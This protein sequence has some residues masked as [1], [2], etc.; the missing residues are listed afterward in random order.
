MN[1]KLYVNGVWIP[2]KEGKTFPVY[3]P[4]TK[5]VIAHVA[6]AG[7][8]DVQK[9]IQAASDAFPLWSR[10]TALERA[11]L[12]RDV[13]DKMVA[14]KEELAYL[15]T[16]EQGKTLQEARGEIQYAADFIRWYSEEASRVYGKTIPASQTDK[17]IM[18]KKEPVGVVAAITPWNFPAAM[19]TRK[20]GPALAV[21]CT[22]IVKPAAETPLTAIRIIEL[23]VEAGVPKGVINLVTSTQS[24]KVGDVFLTDPRV[25]KVT[26]TGSTPVGKEIM[27]KA[28]TTMKNLSLELG[29]HAPSII[30]EDADLED[31]VNQVLQN[32]FRNAGQTCISTNR[33]YVHEKIAGDFIQLFTKKVAHLKVGNGLDAGVDIGPVIHEN[34][35]QKIEQQIKD[36]VEKGALITTGGNRHAQDSYFFQPTVLIDV[37][38]DMLIQQ[39]ETFGPVVPIQTFSSDQ[40]AIQKANG[41]PFGLAA[42]VYTNHIGRATRLI[43]GLEYGIVGLN[44]GL[45]STAQ[46]PF[47]GYKES[48]LGR[49]GGQEGLEAYL[50]TKYVSLRSPNFL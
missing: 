5:E 21:G 10:K 23:F 37:N 47:G 45:P 39:E 8:S 40:E 34:A 14:I 48:G 26:F 44:D 20:I 22:A 1:K 29:G 43:E 33:I 9:A 38:D 49:E 25:R 15:M 11:E 28:S 17:R 2:A 50:E 3:N 24:R 12:L 7:E 36:A 35:V 4:A 16:L 19:I 46:A 32:K 42:Y 31:T 30:L 27:Q 18:V 13:Y 6:D 41:S